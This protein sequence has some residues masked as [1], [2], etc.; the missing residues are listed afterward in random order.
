[1]DFFP[2]KSIR[3]AY[4]TTAFGWCC[5]A[6]APAYAVEKTEDKAREPG[7]YAGMKEGL[8]LQTQDK[9]Y[10]FKFGGRVQIDSHSYDYPTDTLWEAEQQHR[11]LF[12][13]RRARLELA[14]TLSE[15]YQAKLTAEFANNVELKDAYINLRY[16]PAMEI[17]T[18]QFI[19]PFATES[20][21]SSKFNEFAE[22]STIGS[23]VGSGRDRGLML[24]GGSKNYGY[25]YQFAVMNGAPE[26]TP[27]NNGGLDLAARFVLNPTEIV[28]DEWNV[29][30][31]ASYS[32]GKQQALDG[33]ALTLKTESKSGHAFFK[34][35][36]AEDTPYLRKRIAADVTAVNGPTMLKAEYY[37]A[38]YEFSKSV[39]LQGYYLIASYFLTGEQRAVKNGLFDRQLV[40]DV[41]DPAGTGTGAWELAARYSVFYADQKFFEQDGLY[42]GWEPL[43]PAKNVNAGYTWILGVNWYPDTLAR[44]MFDWIRT[45]A[46]KD[47]LAGGLSGVRSVKSIKSESTLLLRVQL[48][49]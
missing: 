11:H 21:T 5:L 7:L 35:E 1:M 45:Y 29:W 23:A 17:R 25:T 34:A 16:F 32:R 28:E 46:A 15:Y 48:E 10:I 13:V 14:V 8:R 3:L 27:D 43:D 4:A 37:S 42:S 39:K 18:G 12:D 24:H 47:E 31:G 30:Y 38:A 40:N 26:N 44:F 20:P 19:Y 22:S 2:L 6:C 9:H 41:Y 49:F 33:D 36:L